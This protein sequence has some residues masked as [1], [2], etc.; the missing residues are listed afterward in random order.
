MNAIFHWSQLDK[1]EQVSIDSHLH[2]IDEKNMIRESV[3][4]KTMENMVHIIVLFFFWSV[5]LAGFL[6][7]M[8]FKV[9][10]FFID[11]DFFS[12][13]SEAS[14]DMIF[15]TSTPPTWYWIYWSVTRNFCLLA[16]PSSRGDANEK[17]LTNGESRTSFILSVDLI[18]PPPTSVG[19]SV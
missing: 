10:I 17:T 13:N 4:E 12:E 9:P 15:P 19:S 2:N 14:N 7:L 1:S 3:L 11:M 18:A 6:L 16:A 5:I 8:N